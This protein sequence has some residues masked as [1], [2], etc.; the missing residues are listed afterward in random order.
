MITFEAA[1]ANIMI[2]IGSMD[3][4]AMADHFF[5][6]HWKINASKCNKI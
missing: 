3:A 2:D 1:V 5:A 6:V 4:R